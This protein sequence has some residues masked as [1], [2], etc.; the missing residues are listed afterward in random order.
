MGRDCFAWSCFWSPSERSGRAA[1][2]RS[3]RLRRHSVCAAGSSLHRCRE[4][5]LR[6]VQHLGHG[7]CGSDHYAVCACTRARTLAG[8]RTGQVWRG[9]SPHRPRPTS[10]RRMRPSTTETTAVSQRPLSATVH[11]RSTSSATARPQQLLGD[12]V[13]KRG[14]ALRNPTAVLQV[15]QL[16][17][18][19]VL[20]LDDELHGRGTRRVSL[21][22]SRPAGRS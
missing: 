4:S 19:L 17:Q 22:R 18:R 12:C 14:H 20:R 3:C 2:S 9:A 15:P 1:R 11:R 21:Q 13:Y 10:Q 16:P 6:R 5:G 7:E 8:P